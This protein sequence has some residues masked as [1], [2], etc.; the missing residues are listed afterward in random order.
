MMIKDGNFGQE[1]FWIL[2]WFFFVHA[3]S[4]IGA[5]SDGTLSDEIIHVGFEKKIEGNFRAMASLMDL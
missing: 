4:F 1:S 2:L 3:E 5:F